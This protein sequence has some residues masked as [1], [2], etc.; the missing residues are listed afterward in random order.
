MTNAQ[1]T[2]PKSLSASPRLRKFVAVSTVLIDLVLM[3]SGMAFDFPF[4]FIFPPAAIILIIL[5]GGTIIIRR[6]VRF[7]RSKIAAFIYFV[8]VILTLD[9]MALMHAMIYG[10]HPLLVL[11]APASYLIA[12]RF[13]NSRPL[14]WSKTQALIV[15]YAVTFVLSVAGDSPSPQQDCSRIDAQPGIRIAWPMAARRKP[16]FIEKLDQDN[17]LLVY[18]K[19]FSLAGARPP[20]LESINRTTG[21]SRVLLKD[22]EVLGIYNNTDDGNIYCVV[23]DADAEKKPGISYLDLV[24][25]DRTG[26]IIQRIPL[27]KGRSDYYAANIFPYGK[28]RLLIV[29]ESNFYIYDTARKTVEY[30]DVY[31]SELTYSMVKFGD[32]LFGVSSKSPIFLLTEPDSVIKYSLSKLK[33]VAK[34]YG[35]P[36]GYYEIRQIGA[37]GRFV[38]AYYMTG[39]GVILDTEINTVRKI[40]IP[41]GTRNFAMDQQGKF[42]FAPNLF[43]GRLQILNI[44][45]NRLLSR[46]FFVGKGTRAMSSL[47]PGKTLISNSCG[48]VEIDHR[49]LIENA[50]SQRP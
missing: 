28:A 47:D 36:F 10:W 22:G 34:R 49:A 15:P 7:R 40:D 13:R 23:V 25:F 50:S 2:T 31:E 42:L 3:V 14:Q 11:V 39:G 19:S 12:L 48:L 16:R 43:S 35:G 44:E 1:V 45:T 27:P 37:T 41:R 21:R 4:Y 38:A 20:A 33:P 18:R 24:V 9:V 29:L 17:F 6:T 26:K 32:N 8:L 5:I 46:N 30:K